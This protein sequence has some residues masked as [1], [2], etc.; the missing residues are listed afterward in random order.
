MLLGAHLVKTPHAAACHRPPQAIA[1]RPSVMAEVLE[2]RAMRGK[3]C[4][5]S[6]QW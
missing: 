5:W 3:L 2:L 1:A 4:R 6:V